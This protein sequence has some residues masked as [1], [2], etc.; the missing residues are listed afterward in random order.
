MK[1]FDKG[2]AWSI[3][4]TV[5]HHVDTFEMVGCFHD[6]VD[7]HGSFGN[8]DGIRFKNISRLVMGETASLNVVGVIG[9]V[10]LNF[11]VDA[12]R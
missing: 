7:L 10:N 8:A 5:N 1:L 11:M 9:Q 4:E 12:A 6:I 2:F 3:G